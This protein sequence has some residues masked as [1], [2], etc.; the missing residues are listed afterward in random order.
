MTI[1]GTPR[2]PEDAVEFVDGALNN[3]PELIVHSGDL[4]AT[5]YALRDLF[6]KAGHLFDR[7][8][9]VKL[10]QP[11]N[12]GAM[13]ARPLTVSGV[14]MEAH[15]FCQPVKIDYNDKHI[16]ITLPDRIARMYLDLIGEWN[17]PPLAGITS[18][19][20][21]AADGTIRDVVGYDAATGLWC[22]NGP[23]LCVPKRP[24]EGDAAAALRVLRDAFK[25]FPF[26]DAVRR[27]DPVLA[28]QIVDLDYPPGRD[29]SAFFAGLLTAVC[30]ASLWLAP[31]F[32]IVAPQVSGAGSGKGLLVRAICVIAFGVRPRAFT[33]GH[34]RQELDKRIVAELVEAAPALFLDNVN[35]TIL[36]SATLACLLTERPAR[37]RLLGY[38]RMVA[39][40]SS[41]FIAVTGNG[42]T[43]S[44]DLARRFVYCELD[45]KCEDPET[46]PFRSGF[47]E[48]IET[49]RHELL[50]AALTILRWGRQNSGS[51]TRGRPLGSF[52]TWSEWVRDP[53]L[54][55]GCADPVE[56][57]EVLKANDPRRQRIAELYQVWWNQHG[58][59]PVKAVALAEAVGNLIDPQG[60]GRQFIASYL[61]Q[62]SGT[63]AAGFVLDRQQPVGKWGAATYSLKRTSAETHDGN[64]H[65]GDRERRGPAERASKPMPPMVPM[66]DAAEKGE[67]PVDHEDK[68]HCDDPSLETEGQHR[69]P[70]RQGTAEIGKPCR[71]VYHRRTA[72]DLFHRIREH[73]EE[74]PRRVRRSA[75]DPDADFI[76]ADEERY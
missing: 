71:F 19:P 27:Y 8:M 54:T 47:L 51:L 2:L 17:L 33:A 20:I 43:V 7:D 64:R 34:D 16:P 31:G 30:R 52:E 65:R 13:E 18:A 15:R 1:N 50:T 73:E 72:E 63:R 48:Q 23:L 32:L 35:V 59:D 61:S 3:K 45:A 42:L 60:R 38:S 29:E 46:R 69:R 70:P 22:C 40:N 44:E 49:R 11:A 6:A 41:A 36:S 53:L 39:L 56:R 55:L 14:V 25:T 57:I 67:A 5:A 37:V 76:G 66:P 75:G 21:I 26:A 4:P 24:R 74:H 58:D 9:P 68:G 12:G 10:V 62:L 28:I